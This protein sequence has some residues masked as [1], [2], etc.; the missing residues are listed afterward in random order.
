MSE[1]IRCLMA[2]LCGRI[3]QCW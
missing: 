1:H 2:I 3:W